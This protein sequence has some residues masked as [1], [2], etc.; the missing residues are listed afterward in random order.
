MANDRGAS[1]VGDGVGGGAVRCCVDVEAAG[2]GG[3]EGT[4]AAAAEDGQ[5]VSGFVDGAIAINA[6]GNGESGAAGAGS[7]DEFWCGT[8][9]EA[10]EVRGIVPRRDDLQDAQAVFA[11]GDESKGA[12]GDH[13][14]FYVVDV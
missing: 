8:R 7:G 6:F 1:F 9:A 3:V 11:V 13:A 5:L 10:G 12:G 2:L 4:G 14:D